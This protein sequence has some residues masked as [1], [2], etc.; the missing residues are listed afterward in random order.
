MINKPKIQ[1]TEEQRQQLKAAV[2]ATTRD[3]LNNRK[4]L[5]DQA[6]T[7]REVWHALIQIPTWTIAEVQ[8]PDDEPLPNEN[9]SITPTVNKI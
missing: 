3:M 9:W 8:K 2:I 5:Q 6:R 4:E 1:L 7:A